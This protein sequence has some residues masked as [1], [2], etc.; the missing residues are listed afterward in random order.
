[1]PEDAVRRHP[2]VSGVFTGNIQETVLYSFY[3]FFPE[4]YMFKKGKDNETAGEAAASAK[5]KKAEETAGSEDDSRKKPKDIKLPGIKGAGKLRRGSGRSDSADDGK[6]KKKDRYTGK[7]MYDLGTV[8]VFCAF[9]TASIVMANCGKEMYKVNLTMVGVT[10]GAAVLAAFRVINGAMILA[11]VQTVIYIGYRLMSS[12]GGDNKI[13]LG[14]ILVPGLAVLGY[15]FIDKAKKEMERSQEVMHE[16]IDELVMTDPVTGLY[17]LRSMYMD[18]QTQISYAERNDKNICL[19]ILRPKYLT[20]LKAVLVKKE[21]N[22]VVVRLS[23]AVCDTVRLEDRVYAIDSEGSFGVILTC[24]LAGAR[25][26]E[27]RLA[28]KLKDNELYDGVKEDYDIRVEMM[29]GCVQYDEEINRDAILFKK[30]AEE[31]MKDL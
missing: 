20:E 27:E 9:I 16:Q 28:E 14:W 25:L 1:M 3:G 26:V 8:L 23:K 12:Q 15:S 2:P 24:D 7:M 5:R 21:F 17:N 29:M 31:A 18:I 10:F 13:S 4:G 30:M 22:D 11:A 6:D 19:M